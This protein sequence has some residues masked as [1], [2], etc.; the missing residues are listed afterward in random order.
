[1]YGGPLL[2]MMYKIVPSGAP[3]VMIYILCHFG[4]RV[5][6]HYECLEYECYAIS[7]YM[8]PL[9]IQKNWPIMIRV[10]Q[11]PIELR[12]IGSIGLNRQT[13]MQVKV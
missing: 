10:A 3:I 12:G 7:W 13:Y 11:K 9:N 5:T 6:Q 1:M 4:Q 2:S 8:L